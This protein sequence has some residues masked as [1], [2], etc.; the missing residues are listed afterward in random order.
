MTVKHTGVVLGCQASRTEM[1]S[2]TTEKRAMVLGPP[3]EG[4]SINAT[5]RMCG[6]LKTAVL[7]LLADAVPWKV[8]QHRRR[9]FALRQGPTQ[10]FS[11][12]PKPLFPGAQ[13][14]IDDT[15]FNCTNTSGRNW[16]QPVTSP[17]CYPKCYSPAAGGRRPDRRHRSL[18]LV[19]RGDKRR[20][21]GDGPVRAEVT[22]DNG[23]IG[24][25]CPDADDAG[26]AFAVMYRGPP[27]AAR[28]DQQSV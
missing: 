10:P 17:N 27:E 7:R 16:S 3:V 21:P 25:G 19:A 11:R 15:A 9:F 14:F 20:H 4:S 2:P 8:F 18:G 5:A 28:G 6:V 13:R 22:G 24:Q 1:R 26:P 12:R 23:L